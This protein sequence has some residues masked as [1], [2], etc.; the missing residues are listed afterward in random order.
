[1]NKILF[2]FGNW[3]YY[4]SLDA[5][6]KS[7]KDYTTVNKFIKLK[8]SDI[9]LDFY[10]KNNKHFKDGRGFGY[11]IWKAYFIN[12]FLRTA[13]DEDV[14]IYADAGNLVCRDLTSL[15][16]LCLNDEKGIILFENTDG[17]PRGNIWKNN[18]WTKSDCF[19]LMGLKTDEYLL[20]NQINAA[21]IVFRKTQFSV[22][23]FKE[24]L[25]YCQN[26]NVISDAPNITEN[27]NTD[28]RD[29]RHD[30]SI[31][32]LLSIKYKI[33]IQRDPSQW[34]NHKINQE[35]LYPQLFL[36]H[37]RNFLV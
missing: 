24:F 17:E 15:Y 32:S 2:S 22:D 6:E 26:Y 16:T 21:Y 30:Q 10:Q 33:T 31:L 5:L 19:N 7:V 4:A 23:L 8:E 27:F 25:T 12:E 13:S 11:W 29:H 3:R 9:D 18:Q 37:R 34:G 20:G 28:F 36:H 1:M 14:F 35:S